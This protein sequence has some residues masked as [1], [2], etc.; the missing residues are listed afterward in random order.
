MSLGMDSIKALACP[1][2]NHRS[3]NSANTANH[4]V[5]ASFSQAVLWC[6]GR[7]V[8]PNGILRQDSSGRLVVSVVTG[9]FVAGYVLK[10][11][12][13]QPQIRRISNKICAYASENH[14]AIVLVPL[15]KNSG[16]TL[17]SAYIEAGRLQELLPAYG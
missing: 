4:R 8:V 12:K 10:R 14:C 9:R 2:I 13:V 17:E 15:H 6:S 7:I 3:L 11:R 5:V 16:T 1:Y